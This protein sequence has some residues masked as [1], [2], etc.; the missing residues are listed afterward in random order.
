[1]QSRDNF[2]LVSNVT[3]LDL[4]GGLRDLDLDFVPGMADLHLVVSPEDLAGGDEDISLFDANKELLEYS[5]IHYINNKE[6]SDSYA[7]KN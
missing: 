5:S 3:D 2:V 1:M 7:L 6:A 4:V